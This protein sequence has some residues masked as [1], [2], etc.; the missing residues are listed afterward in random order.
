[1]CLEGLTFDMS[2]GAKGAKRPL[3]RPLDGGVRPHRSLSV[4]GYVADGYLPTPAKDKG[5]DRRQ[6]LNP[7]VDSNRTR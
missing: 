3:T 2:G 6:K 4:D 5:K 7:Q 1:V